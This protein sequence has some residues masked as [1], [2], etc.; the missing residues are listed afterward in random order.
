MIRFPLFTAAAVFVGLVTAPVRGDDPVSSNVR[1]TGE[2]VRIFDRKCAPCHGAD[3]IAMP[4]VN[5]RQ[6]RD[7]GRAIREEI[8]EQR[9]PPWSVARGYGRFRNELALTARESATILSW[10]DGGMA[11]GDDRDLPATPADVQGRAPDLHLPIPPQPV[12]AREDHVVR[13]V[14]VE[15]NLARPRLLSRLAVTPGRRRLLRGALVFVE[16]EPRAQWIGAWLPWQPS[17]APPPPYTFPLPARARLIVELHYRGG[18]EAT[19][20]APGIDL[21]FGEPESPRPNPGDTTVGELSLD[22]ASPSR[23]LAPTTIWSIVPSAVDAASSVE[24]TARRP[25]GTV[26]LLL[27]IPRFHHEWPQALALQDSVTLPPGTALSLKAEPAAAAATARL[28]LL[29]ANR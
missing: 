10:L 25:N 1:Y 7:W 16:H 12:P 2:I 21:Y 24:L 18:S 17:I 11:R 8:V 14:T 28:G 29:L 9:M 6:V 23:L 19:V 20:D 13:R 27:W 22:T 26:D 3:S 4:L 5:Y 15:T